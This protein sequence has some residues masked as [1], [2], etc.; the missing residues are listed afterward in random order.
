MCH[1]RKQT[2]MQAHTSTNIQVQ[3]GA[4]THT[5]TRRLQSLHRIALEI[6]QSNETTK[7]FR[8]SSSSIGS[9]ESLP[10][11]PGRKKQDFLEQQQNLQRTSCKQLIVEPLHF[12]KAQGKKST[13]T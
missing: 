12:A 13:N 8:S 1:D 9:M 11:G 2:Y 4:H 6:R 3:A 7:G 5:H 10:D